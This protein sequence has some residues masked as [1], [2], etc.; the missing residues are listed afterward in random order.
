MKKVQDETE[1]RRFGMNFS[2]GWVSHRFLIEFQGRMRGVLLPTSGIVRMDVLLCG[3]P[4]HL[5]RN[6]F[7]SSCF[8]FHRCVPLLT[9]RVFC[10]AAQCENLKA[11][12]FNA[13]RVPVKKES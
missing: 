10:W 8:L 1:I 9:T 2:V 6:L 7:S 12:G 3:G 13:P 4:R 5:Q 11:E